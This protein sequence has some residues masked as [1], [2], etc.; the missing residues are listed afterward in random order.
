MELGTHPDFRTGTSNSVLSSPT[1]LPLAR[2]P[3]IGSDQR[4][5]EITLSQNLALVGAAELVREVPLIS[6]NRLLPPTP[7]RKYMPSST[8]ESERNGEM[9]IE[10]ERNIKKQPRSTL[11][12]MSP[13]TSKAP[14]IHPHDVATT[15]VTESGKSSYSPSPTLCGSLITP[16][17]TPLEC[18][19]LAC[20]RLIKRAFTLHGFPALI[21]EILSNEDGGETI[22]RLAV[23][24]AQALIDVIDDVCSIFAC[25][26]KSV[27]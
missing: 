15:S 9:G 5:T 2:P 19:A 20:G 26:S 14:S 1:S 7:E 25:H 10:R 12:N 16:K 24:D 8:R 23:G 18:D 6:G 11:S 13:A 4:G 21:D 17:F 22:R 27:D 3:D